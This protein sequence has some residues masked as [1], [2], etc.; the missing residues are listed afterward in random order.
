VKVASV[1]L[2]STSTRAGQVVWQRSFASAETHRLRILVTGSKR[3]A[4]TSRRV[5]IDAFLIVR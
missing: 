5:D 1:D 2:Y 4:A 3:P